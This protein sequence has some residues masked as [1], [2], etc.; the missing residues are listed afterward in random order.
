MP[1]P[2]DE[3]WTRNGG[4]LARQGD[5]ALSKFYLSRVLEII[6]LGKVCDNYSIREFS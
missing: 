6:L 2:G 5:A 4:P 1:L 3:Q